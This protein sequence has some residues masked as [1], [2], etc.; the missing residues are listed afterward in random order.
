[1]CLYGPPNPARQAAP[2]ARSDCSGDQ[3]LTGP[4]LVA[5]LAAPVSTAAAALD[6]RAPELVGEGAA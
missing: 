5:W 4:P 6:E 2:L 3:T 1:M